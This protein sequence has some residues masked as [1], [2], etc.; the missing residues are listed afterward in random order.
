MNDTLSHAVR[1]FDRLAEQS[2]GFWKLEPN[3][4]IPWLES[5]GRQMLENPYV[6]F[7]IVA[8]G[9]IVFFA[10]PIKAALAVVLSVAV[11]TALPA[12]APILAIAALY[13][14]MKK[15]GWFLRLVIL[16]IAVGLLSAFLGGTAWTLWPFLLLALPILWWRPGTFMTVVI[17][18][19][20]IWGITSWNAD[21]RLPLALIL[22]WTLMARTK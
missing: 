5:Y 3:S 2:V 4:M 21:W 14:A 9:V 20:T 18:V 10:D 15:R 6:F 17:A 19:L 22:V 1:F 16:A 8:I 12:A 13:M 7:P 11:V